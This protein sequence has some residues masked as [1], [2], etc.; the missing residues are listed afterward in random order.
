[1]VIGGMSL[2]KEKSSGDED[3]TKPLKPQHA[4]AGAL[5]NCANPVSADGKEAKKR[6]DDENH[7]R[8]R[9]SVWVG[10]NREHRTKIRSRGSPGRGDRM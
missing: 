7:I 1:M 9:N 10:Y 4:D 8:W 6:F 3:P 2:M 5:K